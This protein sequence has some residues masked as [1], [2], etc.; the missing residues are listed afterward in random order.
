MCET[1]R[2]IFLDCFEQGCFERLRIV[3]PRPTP[4][5]DDSCGSDFRWNGPAARSMQEFASRDAQPATK[6]EQLIGSRPVC[7]PYPATDSVIGK[8]CELGKDALI[9][10]RR[11]RYERSYVFP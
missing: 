2:R 8:H 9:S 3:A 1:R 5:G 4:A 6:A 10:V 11:L 7:T